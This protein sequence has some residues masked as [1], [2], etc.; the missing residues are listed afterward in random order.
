MDR[1]PLRHDPHPQHRPDGERVGEA[2]GGDVDLGGGGAGGR[3]VDSPPSPGVKTNPT[4]GPATTGPL[5]LWLLIQ[6]FALIVA[7]ARVPLAAGYPQP[8]EFLAPHV[9]VVVQ[10][11]AA[12][13]LFPYLLS[14]WSVAIVVIA[15]TWP[16]VILSGL[17]S[18]VPG[19]GLV[20]TAGF[21]SG[22]LL[23]LASL[24]RALPH[25]ARPFGVAAA[26]LLAAGGVV[27][28][29]PDQDF[30]TGSTADLWT[31]ISPPLAA[32]HHL[33]VE[34]SYLKGWPFLY[35]VMGAVG[36][37]RILFLTHQVI[38]RK[39]TISE[40]STPAAIDH[41]SSGRSS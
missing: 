12:A 5:L 21:V 1:R 26:P 10:T 36:L 33:N 35:V 40:F 13:L 23:T 31:S 8:A 4:S 19:E 24:N 11:I 3:P 20:S 18:P 15:T 25:R 41:N 32:V 28:F 22:W 38:H 39:R 37:G 17:L 30:G 34:G 29:Y 16:F 9:M 2:V 6:L 7:T 14:G 27:G